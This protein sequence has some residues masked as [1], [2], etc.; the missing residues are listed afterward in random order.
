MLLLKKISS[1]F[2]TPSHKK[3][4]VCVREI[5]RERVNIKREPINYKRLKNILAITI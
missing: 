1:F 4:E 5:K 2:P 3:A